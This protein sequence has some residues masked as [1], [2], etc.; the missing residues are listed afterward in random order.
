MS[1]QGSPSS[2]NSPLGHLP[3]PLL[4]ASFNA[5][6]PTQPDNPRQS[7]TPST[8]LSSV[9]FSTSR[10]IEQ[11]Q[12]VASELIT[13]TSSDSQ[14]AVA[15]VASKKITMT[16]TSIAAV[17]GLV[18]TASV[19]FQQLVGAGLQ[20]APGAMLSTIA[21]EGIRF[22]SGCITGG[23]RVARP[24]SAQMSL[25]GIWSFN[26]S[27]MTIGH[28]VAY[29]KSADQGVANMIVMSSIIPGML[30][31]VL[32]FRDPPTKSKVAA[33]LLLLGGCYTA[34][35]APGIATG[36]A[37]GSWVAIK[38]AIACGIAINEGARRKMAA[39]KTQDPEKHNYT[40]SQAMVWVGGLSLAMLAPAAIGF[41][42]FKNI[43]NYS[44]TFWLG[45][46][47]MAAAVVVSTVLSLAVYVGGGSV[48]A[49]KVVTTATSVVGTMAA[50]TLLF[51]ESFSLYKLFGGVMVLGAT[52]VLAI[53][54]RKK[55]SIVNK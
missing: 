16:P 44:P 48:V 12:K 10:S 54:D 46:A 38:A 35:G 23:L 14:V 40:G 5:S 51:D 50:G 7:V 25:M 11:N 34:L 20:T 39:L 9:T 31:D 3:N 2:D 27:V 28:I 26:A 32:F 36:A 18:R 6:N 55:S 43:A 42:A 8:E 53:G 33:S 41:G 29:S 15:P 47:G 4:G 30:I 17:D 24:S 19:S 37:L 45:T 1:T 49:R 22:A 13:G 52:V 21:V